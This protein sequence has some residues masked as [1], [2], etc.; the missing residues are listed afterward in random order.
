MA[1]DA[2][3]H[4][5]ECTLV[6][7]EMAAAADGPHLFSEYEEGFPD[8]DMCCGIMPTNALGL[9]SELWVLSGHRVYCNFKH[10]KPFLQLTS[11]PFLLFVPMRFESN[12]EMA[13]IRGNIV[14]ALRESGVKARPYISDKESFKSPMTVTAGK[15]M[16]VSELDLGLALDLLAIRFVRLDVSWEP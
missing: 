11:S 14:A 15:G 7:L 4:A 16:P 8:F 12:E 3:Q 5:Q 6:F 13:T 1:S 10:I 2:D 9:L